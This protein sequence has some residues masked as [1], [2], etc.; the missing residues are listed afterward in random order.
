MKLRVPAQPQFRM[1]HLHPGL[2]LHLVLLPLTLQ[3]R[4]FIICPPLFGFILSS[5]SDIFSSFPIC[6]LLTINPDFI[7][8]TLLQAAFGDIPLHSQQV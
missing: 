1:T 3:V 8:A 7:P 2:T 5:G 6:D 4:V